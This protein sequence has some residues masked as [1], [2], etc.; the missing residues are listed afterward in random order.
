[1]FFVLPIVYHRV[2]TIQSTISLITNPKQ[3]TKHE[4]QV[5][6]ETIMNKNKT[7]NF[8][9]LVTHCNVYFSGVMI[10][11]HTLK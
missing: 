10:I 5:G 9:L 11:D 7:V 2:R 1:M 3:G 4:Y 6:S 8:H